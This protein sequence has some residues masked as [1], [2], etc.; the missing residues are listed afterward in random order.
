M[1]FWGSYQVYI[2]FHTDHL[3][4][5]TDNLEICFRTHLNLDAPLCVVQPLSKT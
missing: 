3:R 2:L 5:V 4:I 1:D